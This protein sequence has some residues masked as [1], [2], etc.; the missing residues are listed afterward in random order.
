MNAAIL[1]GGQSLR[2]GRNKAFLSIRGHPLIERQIEVLRRI[3]DRILLVTR[4]PREYAYLAGVFQETTVELVSDVAPEHG[5]MV[6]IYSGLL[7]VHGHAGF[8]V[9][10]DMPFLN[11]GLIR[12]MIGLSADFDIVIPQSPGGLEP[13]HAVYSKACLGP[14]EAQMGAG[15]YRIIHFFSQMHVRVVTEEES[16]PFDPLGMALANINTEEEFRRYCGTK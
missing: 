10:C 12:F 9:A 1:C 13:T 14:M 2:M 16:R 6:G 8:F 7:S 4:S 3:F 15:D 5:S 11:E